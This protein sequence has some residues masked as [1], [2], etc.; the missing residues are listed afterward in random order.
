MSKATEYA[1]RVFVGSQV[2]ATY[3]PVIRDHSICG[4]CSIHADRTF[5]GLCRTCFDE[6]AEHVSKQSASKRKVSKKKA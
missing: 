2:L 3:F 1:D 5:A 4:A 6:A